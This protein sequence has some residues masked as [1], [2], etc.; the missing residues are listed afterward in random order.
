MHVACS[1][2][3]LKLHICILSAGKVELKGKRIE[4]EHSVPKKQRY[5][6]AFSEQ[7]APVRPNV[8][9][10]P[11]L[12]FLIKSLCN[13]TIFFLCTVTCVVWRFVR[14]WRWASGSRCEAGVSVRRLNFVG[15][16]CGGE[17]PP[18]GS[19]RWGF[20]PAQVGPH[21]PNF[22]D[23]VACTPSYVQT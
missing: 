13:G 22:Q 10:P 3:V 21:T 11:A 6:P 7:P 4:V 5:L 19:R 16:Y 8:L 15:H 9:R 23:A 17:Q 1:Y 14:D 2:C 18:L 12:D 20:P